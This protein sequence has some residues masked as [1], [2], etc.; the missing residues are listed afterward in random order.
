LSAGSTVHWLTTL[1]GGVDLRGNKE[2]SVS[3]KE[4]I[5]MV[6]GIRYSNF[7]GALQREGCC[8][9]SMREDKF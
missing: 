2:H 3:V 8:E 9:V 6:C 4:N 1:S 7:D 5:G